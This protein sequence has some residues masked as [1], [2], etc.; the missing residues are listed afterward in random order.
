ML[1]QEY[2]FGQNLRQQNVINLAHSSKTRM[3]RDEERELT[4]KASKNYVDDKDTEET[5]TVMPIN[6]ERFLQ[7]LRSNLRGFDED[8]K[9]VRRNFT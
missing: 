2:N 5:K 3:Y 8:S 7:I 6:D 9:I 4:L 1:P